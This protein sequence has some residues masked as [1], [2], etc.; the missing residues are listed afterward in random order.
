MFGR[1]YNLKLP[2]RQRPV[3]VNNARFILKKWARDRL[4][5]IG[6]PKSRLIGDG[7]L[8]DIAKLIEQ[9]DTRQ[10]QARSVKPAKNFRSP[11]LGHSGHD[12]R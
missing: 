4:L 7:R 8:I 3:R 2:A 11:R 1:R 10:L 6:K 5:E 12:Q 9:S